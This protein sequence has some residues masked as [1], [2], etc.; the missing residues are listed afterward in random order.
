MVNANDHPSLINDYLRRLIT[1]SPKVYGKVN[2]RTAR[3][4]YLSVYV[5]ENLATGGEII[6]ITSLVARSLGWKFNKNGIRVGGVG[7]CHIQDIADALTEWAT[8]KV[9][10][11]Q[12]PSN[13][14]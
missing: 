14:S 8:S 13:Y 6:D 1:A 7:T 2:K 5:V 10:Y 3:E 12:L 11:E 9:R 4:S